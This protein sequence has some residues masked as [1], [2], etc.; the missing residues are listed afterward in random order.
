L[1]AP[2]SISLSLIEQGAYTLSSS[3][4]E[5]HQRGGV[6][7]LTEVGRTY[8]DACER[9]LAEVEK[10]SQH[11]R[12]TSQNCEGP[13]TLAVSDNVAN[14]LLPQLLKK[15]TQTHPGVQPR[16]FVGT[17]SAIQAEL[18][19]N[20]S[21]LGI[22]YADREWPGLVSTS[23]GFVEFWIVVS[24]K[25]LQRERS[26]KWDAL[27]YIGSRASD[28]KRIYPALKMLNSIGVRPSHTIETN[29]QETQKRLAVEGLGYT[30]VPNFM[31]RSEVQRGQL[32]K[33]DSKPV[34]GAE[35]YLVMRNRK[36]RSHPT[37]TFEQFL[38]QHGF[39]TT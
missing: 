38:K 33:I 25:L 3:G 39:L 24:P 8:V 37:H 1:P 35:L 10:L 7:D 17:G 34:I 14:Y 12:K 36:V 28:Y 6:V 11:L 21:E 22:F 4:G 26:Q 5:P 31:V 15:F 18:I 27:A 20:R 9:I 32:I 16:I 30:V 23:L 29:N 2:A 13:L 19:E